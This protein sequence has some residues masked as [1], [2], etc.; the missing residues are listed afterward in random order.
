MWRR[1]LAASNKYRIKKQTT[2]TSNS[3]NDTY[4]FIVVEYTIMNWFGRYY[5]K[6]TVHEYL[7]VGVKLQQAR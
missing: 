5:H 6:T 4:S 1:I 7:G 2:G 3:L